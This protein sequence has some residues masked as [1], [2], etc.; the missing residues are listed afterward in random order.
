MATCSIFHYNKT[1]PRD[2]RSLILIGNDIKSGVYKEPIE[3]IRALI[4]EGKTEEA[5]KL[6]FKLKSFSP[7]A[8]F[9]DRRKPEF[10][11]KYSYYVHLDFD[12]IKPHEIGDVLDKVKAS[13]YTFMCFISVRGCG[14]KIFIEVDTGAEHHSV[15]YQQVKD[16]YEKLL[17]LKSDPK[18]KDIGRL[19]FVSDDP[20]LYKN[21]ANEKFHVILPQNKQQEKKSYTP[22]D[23]DLPEVALD[24]VM[25]FHQQMEFTNKK[26]QYSVG[27][28][29]NYVYSLASNCNRVG[30]P[31]ESTAEL[32]FQFFDLSE[33][34]IMASV[35]SAYE[36]HT[37]EFAKFAK[38]AKTSISPDST[39]DD[40]LVLGENIDGAEFNPDYLSSTP[41]IPDDVCQKLPWVLREGAR[42]YTDKRKRDVFITGALA[43]LSGCLPRVMGVYFQERVYPHLYTFVIAPA[44]NGK[45]VLKNAKRLTQKYHEEVVKNSREELEKYEIEL[46]EYNEKK[47]KWKSGQPV[48]KPPTKPA[49]K[50]VMIPADCS[51]ARIVEHLYNNGGKG[52]ICETEADIM[53]GTKKQ[54]WG[55]YSPLLRM[56]FHHEKYTYS[57]KT[58]DVFLEIEEPCLALALGGTPGQ[59]PKLISSAE[60]GLFSRILYYAYKSTIGWQ[61]PSPNAN[62]VVFNDHFDQLSD[63]VL[64]ITKHLDQFPTEV[65]L[66]NEQWDKLNS[67]FTCILDDVVVFSSEDAAGIVYRLGLILFRFCMIFTA[68]RKFEARDMKPERYCSDEDFDS[69]LRLAQV[70]LQHSI[71]MF[72]NLPNQKEVAPYLDG[73]N[74]KKFFEKLPQEFQRKDAITLGKKCNLSVRSVDEIL[75]LASN[76]KLE[77]LKAGYYRKIDKSDV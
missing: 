69:A 14:V 48:P 30:I 52:I 51:Y 73:E 43:I 18:C 57:R 56:A 50:I 76:T 27:D 29:N 17:G 45:G 38:S 31:Q 35:R 66:T 46:L 53:S 12:Y 25:L 70:Y 8:T 23:I 49:F 61:D 72:N 64:K 2:E 26:I 67:S 44:A 58:N 71:L 4:S 60:D 63:E 75:K 3:K 21:L 39:N 36:H 34:E 16:Y 37:H 6:K 13:R 1:I 9:T 65:L 5:D 20:N 24:A 68:L 32:I 77:K 54:E 59:V 40:K 47:R 7:S 10:L 28:R 11:K 15:A 19:C 41:L 62:P 74:K 42:V 55:D 22:K 33:K